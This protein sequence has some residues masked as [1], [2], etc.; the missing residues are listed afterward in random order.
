MR[1]FLLTRRSFLRGAAATV[2]AV[3]AAACQPAVVEVEKV[4]TKEV[5]KVVK[6]TVVVTE[7][8]EVK[9]RDTELPFKYYQMGTPNSGNPIKLTYW[10]YSSTEVH[11]WPKWFDAYSQAYPNV[12]FEITEVP[13]TQMWTKLQVAIPAGEA[14]DFFY[15]HQDGAHWTIVMG[16]LLQPLPEEIFPPAEIQKTFAALESWSGP[17]GRAY[18]LPIGAMQGC[19][20]YN[21]DMVQEAGIDPDRDLNTWDGV[22]EAAK[23]MTKRDAAGRVE[24]AGLDIN[25]FWAWGPPFYQQGYFLWPKG[26]RYPC[27]NQEPM[28][29][30]L[31]FFWDVN[32][33]HQVCD[34]DFLN[35]QDG[36][37]AGK[38]GMNTAW[39]WFTRWMRLNHPTVNFGV[40]PTPTWS[41]EFA[42]ATGYGSPDPQSPGVPIT[43]PPE[44]AQVC[45]DV[46]AWLYSRPD[47][48]IDL[49]I[50]KLTPPA[51]PA[52]ADHPLLK[53]EPTLAPL[54]PA[55]EWAI[56]GR[57]GAPLAGGEYGQYAGEEAI[58]ASGGNIREAVAKGH[59]AAKKATLDYKEEVGEENFYVFEHNYLH[60]DLMK[61]PDC[62]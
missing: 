35:W 13:Y 19:L 28:I 37:A 15:V 44:R 55:A 10:N 51:I 58:K 9:V 16:G 48:L 23:A 43:T 62:D 2:S 20:Y 12:T 59:E 50:N 40:R 60:A 22:I 45:F 3:L 25:G 54:L 39:N 6:E 47:Y 5:E 11:F 36:F 46:I 31:E 42:P 24:Q 53:T 26:Y 30:A 57:G 17:K 34:D 41:G 1:S 29:K 38:V 7:R 14:P 49:S 61:Y 27:Y 18:W 56:L 52:L 33:K 32:H 4:V 8:V 21:Q